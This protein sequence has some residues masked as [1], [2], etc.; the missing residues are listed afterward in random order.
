[1]RLRFRTRTEGVPWFG[2]EPLILP[3]KLPKL[4]ILLLLSCVEAKA[5][6]NFPL[7]AGKT[8]E[9]EQPLQTT[10]GGSRKRRREQRTEHR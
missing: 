6:L 8:A 3:S 7:E 10:V 9:A 1:M 2:L 5:I 4:M